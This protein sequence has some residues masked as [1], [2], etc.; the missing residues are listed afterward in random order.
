MNKLENFK[1]KRNT[2]GLAENPQNINRAGR[3]ISIKRQ[4]KEMLNADGS[5]TIIKEQIK[6]INEDGSVTIEI[7]TQ[8]QLAT[9]LLSW[10]LSDNSRESIKAIQMIM[11][12]VDGK[13][14]QD[15]AVSNVEIKPTR[16]IDATIQQ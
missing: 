10:A 13:P 4:L 8:N 7:P 16:Y 5:I 9:K 3:P 15:V 1:G 6:S 11:E 2:N 12:Q 14:K